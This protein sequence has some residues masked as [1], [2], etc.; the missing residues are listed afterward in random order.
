[1]RRQLPHR[2]LRRGRVLQLAALPLQEALLNVTMLLQDVA[3][4]AASK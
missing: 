4:D 3:S 1:M 2:G